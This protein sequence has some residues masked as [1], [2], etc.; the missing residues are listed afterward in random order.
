MVKAFS[1]SYELFFPPFKLFNEIRT[2]LRTQRPVKWNKLRFLT[3][4]LRKISHHHSI[5]P[6]S[7]SMPFPFK[8]VF[9]VVSHTSFAYL[10]LHT[11]QCT[12]FLLAT[13]LSLW[14]HWRRV[15]FLASLSVI[16][17]NLVFFL[18]FTSATPHILQKN[19]IKKNS[20][21]GSI[22]HQD[23]IPKYETHLQLLQND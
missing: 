11:T 18:S 16:T 17:G 21:I 3:L 13:N 22:Q 19:V 15:L 1:L 12:L 6:V 14:P 23:L 20:N 9:L 7:L 4:N 10:R 2:S 5:T 8:I